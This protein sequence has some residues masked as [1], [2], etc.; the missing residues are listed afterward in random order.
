M[1]IVY[2]YFRIGWEYPT[3]GGKGLSSKSD[4]N[5]TGMEYCHAEAGISG[6]WERKGR[7]H[8]K[9][10]SVFLLRLSTC[11]VVIRGSCSFLCV[12]GPR[13]AKWCFALQMSRNSLECTKPRLVVGERNHG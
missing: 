1:T 13:L 12:R 7:R 5:M 4:S 10:N 3:P 8:V 2:A 9:E 11:L 6:T